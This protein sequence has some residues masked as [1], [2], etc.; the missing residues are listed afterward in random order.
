MVGDSIWSRLEKIAKEHRGYR[1]FSFK[2]PVEI[3]LNTSVADDLGLHGELAEDFLEDLTMAFPEF[4]LC[5]GRGDFCFD[6]YFLSE[7]SQ[8]FMPGFIYLFYPKLKK[9]DA[10][11]KFPL[12]LGMLQDAIS[13]G[14]WESARYANE[15]G[16]D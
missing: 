3:R 1:I 10:E 13:R 14:Y 11:T 16:G 4:E 9:S 12:T 7:I 6:N 15:N 2:K 8:H 5:D